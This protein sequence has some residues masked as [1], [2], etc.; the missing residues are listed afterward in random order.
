MD[1]LVL[2]VIIILSAVFHE[3]GHG[4][5]ALELGDPTARNSG[6]L[7]LN[8]VPH[9]DMMGTVIVPLL[10]LF[11]FG[12]FIGWAKPVP[13]NPL[14]FK[15]RRNGILKVSLAGVSANL[16]LAVVFGLLVR[17]GTS[18]LPVAAVV[19]LKEVVIVNISLALF[20]LLPFPPLD[21]S[22]I[23]YELFP[24]AWAGVMRLGFSGVILAILAASAILPPVGNLIF[25]LLTGQGY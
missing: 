20:N 1:I 19:L 16:L 7:T 25:K 8:P 13:I 14:F 6:R 2:Y 22:Q 11:S 23:F 18:V 15:D 21:G 12:S 3:Y 24:K 5:M 4:L 9:L 17:F 10:S